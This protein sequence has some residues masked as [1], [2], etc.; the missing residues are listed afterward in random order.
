ME[1]NFFSHLPPLLG[2]MV[3]QSNTPTSI[4]NY[5]F[6]GVVFH[7]FP[8][9]YVLITLNITSK[10]YW[11]MSWVLG[12]L[13]AGKHT[14]FGRVCKGMD[15]VKRLGIVETDKHDRWVVTNHM[16]KNLWAKQILPQDFRLWKHEVLG[17]NLGNASVALICWF[18]SDCLKFFAWF[19]KFSERFAA[20]SFY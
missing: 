9:L 2:L 5:K 1:A 14:I 13:G 7:H 11:L 6:C 15:V 20:S 18:A 16:L 12:K 8:V 3:S 4:A 17:K 10:E 19:C